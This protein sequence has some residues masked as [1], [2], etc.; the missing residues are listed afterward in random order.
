MPP[1][2]DPSP[3]RAGHAVVMI[4]V[5]HRTRARLLGVV[6]DVV[7]A[8]IVVLAA[9]A[10]FPNEPVGKTAIGI[11]IAML[12]AVFLPLRRFVP[13]WVLVGAVACFV[14]AAATDPVTP[15]SS[16]AVGVAV[17]GVGVRT[18]RRRALLGALGALVPMVAILVL[19]RGTVI[20]PSVFQ[21]IVTLGFAAAAGDA[22][23]TRR[24][25]VAEITARAERAE[26][27][28]E[29]EASRRVAEERL[30]IARDLHDAVAHQISVI[31][32]SAG[33]A[34]SAM[35]DRPQ[36]AREALGT[37]R[38]ASREVLGEIGELLAM[39]RS[40]DEGAAP[41]RDLRQVGE[42]V[43]RYAE[44]G[45]DVTLRVD[46][47]LDALPLGIDVVAYRVLQEA[48]TNAAKHGTGGRAHVLIE[49]DPSRL[50]LV[51]TN[52]IADDGAGATPEGGHGLLGIRERVAS[53][54][55]TV[56]ATST[57]GAFRLE[58]TLPL[59]RDGGDAA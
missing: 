43:E 36:V 28:R 13:G 4:P 51:V 26:Q 17:Y 55:G 33:V 11:V 9:L 21:V 52:P 12:P 49:R 34:S 57:G 16:F 40:T 35:D 31:S 25:Y 24:A 53:V 15:F 44:S 59:E 7:V 46:G 50:R 1:G 37:I 27:T 41:P 47:E 42:L 54:R 32:L 58:A 6:G 29:S 45:L 3:G 56:E 19:S 38:S 8:A 18:D 23:R 48:L 22:V 5:E 14:V 2:V 30:R 39:L 10:H 20:D